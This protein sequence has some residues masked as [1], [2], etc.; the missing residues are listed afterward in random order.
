VPAEGQYKQYKA[1]HTGEVPYALDN[2]SFV[3]RPW[4]AVDHELATSMSDYWV[5]FVKTGN[6]NHGKALNWPLFNSKEKPTLYFDA[7]FVQAIDVTLEATSRFAIPDSL[8]AEFDIVTPP[9]GDN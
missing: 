4:E 8:L 7:N 5:S 1:F 6:P 3:N 9:Q 2:L